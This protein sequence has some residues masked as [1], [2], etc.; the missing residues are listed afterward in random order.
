MGPLFLR[1]ILNGIFLAEKQELPQH[2][3]GNLVHF[4]SMELPGYFV[5]RYVRDQA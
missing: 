2:G 4:R 3:L 5:L 1:S